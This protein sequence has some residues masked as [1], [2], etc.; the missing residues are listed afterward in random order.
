MTCCLNLT[1]YLDIWPQKEADIC[2]M[3]QERI[4]TFGSL[5]E[6][7]EMAGS[8]NLLRGLNTWK[9]SVLEEKQSDPVI[10]LTFQAQLDF[11]TEY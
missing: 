9:V 1:I 8:E 5:Q 7:K 10:K 6:H 11:F 2:P 3:A 4:H